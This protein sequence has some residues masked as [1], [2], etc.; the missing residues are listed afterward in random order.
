MESKK[1]NHHI[2]ISL[3]NDEVKVFLK[4]KNVEISDDK[5]YYKINE[6]KTTLHSL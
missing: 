3:S 4:I 1:D 6:N 5:P 2:N